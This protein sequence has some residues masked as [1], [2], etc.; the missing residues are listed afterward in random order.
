MELSVSKRTCFEAASSGVRS[1][2]TSS[3]I[4]QP[5]E[6]GTG[7][8][9]CNGFFFLTRSSAHASVEYQDDVDARESG[10]IALR[11]SREELEAY[12]VQN[13]FRI[14]HT[15]IVNADA[16]TPAEPITEQHVAIC[17]RTRNLMPRFWMRGC[18]FD[19]MDSTG[20]PKQFPQHRNGC[21]RLYRA[22]ARLWA[23]GLNNDESGVRD[24]LTEGEWSTRLDS[25]V[26][27]AL[28]ASKSELLAQPETGRLIPTSWAGLKSGSRLTDE[29]VADAVK[30]FKDHFVPPKK[31]AEIWLD[32]TVRWSRDL[33]T[34]VAI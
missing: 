14:R 1:E 4:K 12:E 11:Y 13:V 2:T 34:K 22:M 28:K 26:A 7:T 5:V 29:Q 33:E 17:R 9:A 32:S 3:T 18:L 16:A 19:L 27:L 15:I 21:Q 25:T 23:A 10:A 30:K 8:G 24:A 20:R 31:E 6:C